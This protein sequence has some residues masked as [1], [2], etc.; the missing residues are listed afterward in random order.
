MRTGQRSY[1]P[2]VGAIQV[3][4]VEQVELA[5]LTEDDACRDGFD[6]VDALRKEIDSIY[7]QDSDE[8]PRQPYRVR[9]SI[10]VEETSDE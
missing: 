6:S 7:G 2:G 1:I 3:H 5:D 9:F 10:L 4:S 8:Q